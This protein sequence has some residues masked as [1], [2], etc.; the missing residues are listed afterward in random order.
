MLGVVGV[1]PDE[2]SARLGLKP[3]KVALE[4]TERIGSGGRYSRR[5]K[6]V[7]LLERAAQT[8]DEV[9]GVLATLV[10]SLAPRRVELQTIR[11]MADRVDIL[12]GLFIVDGT[13]GLELGPDLLAELAQLGL[14]VG[15]DVY[16]VPDPD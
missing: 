14:A 1:G 12:V 15:I 3:T 5:K 9:V 8:L 6:D 16:C 10:E 7:W 2:V 4:G 11:H 13:G